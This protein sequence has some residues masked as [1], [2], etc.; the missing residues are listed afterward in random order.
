LASSSERRAA[1]TVKPGGDRVALG[2]LLAEARSLR[3]P[4][5][6]AARM[7]AEVLLAKYAKLSRSA[8]IAFPER[9][10]STEVANAFR[11]AYA[12]C[13]SGEPLAYVLGEQEFYSLNLRVT[14]D[15]LVPRP[16]TEILVDELLECL[17]SDRAA[18]VLDIGTG[19]GAVAL[20]IKRAR[21]L[22]ALTAVDVSAAALA[23]AE[24]NG[25]RLGLQ[26]RW[27]QSRWLEALADERF[28]AIVCNPPYVPSDDPH[29]AQLRF[30]PRLALDGGADGL[31]CI[32]SLLRLARPQL[33]P[34]GWLVLEHGYDQQAEVATLAA[35]F[36]Y[37]V[38][39]LRE[40]LNGQPRVAVLQVS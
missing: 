25:Q 4:G 2:T 33:Q 24:D 35:E 30:E 39:R 15:V 17:P 9:E 12:R 11:S 20:A 22:W 32:R 23:V 1:G 28:S 16:D 31:A 10:V 37:R 3:A 21:P 26:V 7:A 5:D 6:S 27:L 38:T 8:V 19:S 18:Q 36:A 34:G 40:D 29:F 14:P 13:R